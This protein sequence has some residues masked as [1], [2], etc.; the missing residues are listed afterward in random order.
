MPR[1]ME[2]GWGLTHDDEFLYASDGTSKIFK[3]NPEDFSVIEVFKVR[4]QNDNSIHFINELELV[5]DF[6]FAN[7]LPQ[8]IILKIDKSSG[9]VDKIYDFSDLYNIQ[10]K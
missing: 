5:G 2:E 9:K 7:V 3:I 8:N 10:K 4:D 6:I 1:E